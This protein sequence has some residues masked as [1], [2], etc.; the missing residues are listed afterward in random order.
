MKCLDKIDRR[1]NG[2]FDRINSHVD[3]SGTWH[4]KI[5]TNALRTEQL[6]NEVTVLR[7]LIFGLLLSIVGAWVAVVLK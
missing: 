7:R 2:S 4:R 3:D 5:E 1:I 6:R